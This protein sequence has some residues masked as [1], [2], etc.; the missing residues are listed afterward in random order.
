MLEA[1]AQ[2]TVDVTPWFALHPNV[3][4]LVP[5]HPA[6]LARQFRLLVVVV[7]SLAL[8]DPMPQR[9]PVMRAATA[10]LDGLD[11]RLG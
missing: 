8:N 5:C 9:C 11:Q 7:V 1:N 10:G 4:I 3:S 2:S 6:G